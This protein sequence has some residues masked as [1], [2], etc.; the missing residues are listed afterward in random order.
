MRGPAR[1]R[2][3]WRTILLR[4]NYLPC[5][6]L[7]VFGDVFPGIFGCLRLICTYNGAKWNSGEAGFGQDSNEDIESL[8]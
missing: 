8:K 1:R 5:N 4:A 7:V 6:D 2:M 3:I